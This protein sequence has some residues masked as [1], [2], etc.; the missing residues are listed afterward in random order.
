MFINFVLSEAKDFIFGASLMKEIGLNTGF[1]IPN[2][3]RNFL[4]FSFFVVIELIPMITIK[5]LIKTF[6]IDIL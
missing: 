3:E 6:L 5:Q 4:A 2:L 1:T